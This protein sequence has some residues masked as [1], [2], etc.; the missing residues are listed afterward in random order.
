M[1]YKKVG[2]FLLNK[3]NPFL[4]DTAQHIEKGDKVILMS[5]DSADRVVS[6][7]GEV[8]GHSLFAKRIKIDKAQFTKIY[9][10][11]IA[12]WFG[13]SKAGIRIFGYVVSILKP[14][15]DSFN[16]DFQNCM[17]FTGYTARKTI[18][19][20]MSE[21]LENKF[22]ARGANPYHFFINPTVFFNGDRVSFLERYEIKESDEENTSPLSITTTHT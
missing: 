3:Q 1:A 10:N 15:N 22:I 7:E 8:R 18:I 14:N 11:N 5:T 2:E 21:L 6:V 4:M 17:E 20:G 12:V 16:F 19:T 13:L 9:I